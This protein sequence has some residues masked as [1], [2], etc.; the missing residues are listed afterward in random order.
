MILQRFSVEHHFSN[1][2]P[3]TSLTPEVVTDSLKERDCLTANNAQILLN[4]IYKPPTCIGFNNSGII[5][6]LQENL[7]HILALK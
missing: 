3:L 6:S 5:S 4:A 1:W 2:Y 7:P